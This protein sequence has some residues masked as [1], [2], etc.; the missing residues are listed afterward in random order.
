MDE[1]PCTYYICIIHSILPSYVSLKTVQFRSRQAL[2]HWDI[3][4][5]YCDYRTNYSFS[6]L[7][8]D[9]LNRYCANS[10][11][12]PYSQ[13][14]E[15]LSLTLPVP[16]GCHM[17][18]LPTSTSNNWIQDI[19]SFPAPILPAIL[20]ESRFH[21]RLQKRMEVTAAWITNLFRGDISSIFLIRKS[22][23]CT[24]CDISPCLNLRIYRVCG[25]NVLN[26]LLHRPGGGPPG[27]H[28]R[29]RC[30]SHK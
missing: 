17:G 29:H 23:Y 27:K 3:G 5:C 8:D 1:V 25:N 14:A 12:M 10:L 22:G 21:G 16:R 19:W 2:W 15:L 7:I 18:M 6:F 13:D 28:P 9:Y 24:V 26:P 11:G 30:Y 4:T 20:P